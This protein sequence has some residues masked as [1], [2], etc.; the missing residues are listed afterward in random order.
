M[1][2]FD[3]FL[4]YFTV[5]IGFIPTIYFQYA[6]FTYGFFNPVMIYCIIENTSK[7]IWL[8]NYKI[9]YIW[10][11]YVNNE[12]DNFKTYEIKHLIN[13]IEGFSKEKTEEV[14]DIINEINEKID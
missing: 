8:N 11:K 4:Y 6:V 5:F 7:Y 10:D 1:I 14:I 2:K 9:K 13:T 3:T 12:Q